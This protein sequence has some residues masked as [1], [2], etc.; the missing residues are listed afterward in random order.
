MRQFFKFML[1][2]MVGMLLTM[3]ILFFIVGGIIAAMVSSAT[4]EK[5]TKLETNSVLEITLNHPILERGSKNPFANFDPGTMKSRNPLGLEEILINIKKAS[6]DDKIKGIYLHVSAVRTGFATL[7]EIRNALIDFKKS[8]KFLIAYAESYSQGAYYLASVADKIYLNPEGE[9]DF[10]GL[11][12]ELTFFKGALEKLEI[13][14]EVIRHGKFK[15]AIEPYINDKM[16]DENRQ[17]LAALLDDLW[18]HLLENISAARKISMPELKQLADSYGAHEAE[19]ALKSKLIDGLEYEDQVI[20]SM[21]SKTGVAD[22]E[23]LHTITLSGYKN[24]PESVRKPFVKEK[25]AVIYAQGIIESGSGEETSIGSETFARAI[26]KAAMNENIKAIVL[27]V[28]SPGGS[29]MASEVIWRELTLAKKSKPVVVSMGDLAASGGYY[30]SCGAD[31]IFA[32]ANTI[33]GS[34]GVFG[35]LFNAKKLLNNK[36]GI[37]TDT[38]KTAPFADIGTFTRP[39]SD[40]ERNILQQSVDKIYSTFTARVADGRKMSRADVD[41]IG[42]GRVWSGTDALELG[43]VDRIGGLDEAILTAARMAKIDKYRIVSLPQQKEPLEEFL[44]ALKDD[45][46][47]SIVKRELGDAYAYYESMQAMLH[48]KGVQALIPFRI[49][50]E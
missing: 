10:K 33:T 9:V 12:A 31:S 38:Y 42:Q 24:V 3:F 39:L 16:S 27:R 49:N 43:L 47:A 8:G 40:E 22:K 21:K 23:E 1:A 44:K 6:T 34:I 26:H 50:A 11:R 25:I 19:E 7:E 15:S 45:T 2:S 41:S 13:E 20:S 32:E 30:I 4:S 36:L 48:L 29:A 17:Q 35:L 14:P 37:T 18:G 46:E 5:E 28:N